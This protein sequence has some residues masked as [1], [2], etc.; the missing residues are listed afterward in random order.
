MKGK[1][2]SDIKKNTK[3]KQSE[4]INF[5]TTQY[6]VSKPTKTVAKHEHKNR[7]MKIGERKTN[8]QK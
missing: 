4:I 7:V 2:V 8:K 1:G 6:K 5:Y 3:T